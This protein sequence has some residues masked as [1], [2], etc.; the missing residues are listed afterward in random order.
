ML[1][2]ERPVLLLSL[3]AAP[4][5]WWLLRVRVEAVM[6]DR[7]A[8][9]R[10]AAERVR[11]LRPRARWQRYV[12]ALGVA[13]LGLAL[14]GLRVQEQ[15][16]LRRCHFVVD[17][18]ASMLTRDE[19]AG[20]ARFDAALRAALEDALPDHVERFVY[21]LDGQR[22]RPLTELAPSVSVSDLG[23]TLR[24]QAGD[25]AA[26][27][28]VAL[29]FAA[30]R[31]PSDFIVVC[32][33][34]AGLTTWPER[35]SEGDRVALRGF[36]RPETT[37]SG[38]RV[39]EVVDPWPLPEI[40]LR[41]E[42][43]GHGP[44]RALTVSL[45]GGAASR[46]VAVDEAGKVNVQR[47]QGGTLWLRQEPP[48]LL[49]V[50]DEARV[51]VRGPWSPLLFVATRPLATESV[52]EAATTLLRFFEGVLG[53]EAVEKAAFIAQAPQRKAMSIVDGGRLAA[54]PEDGI[55]RILFA[56]EVAAAS[57]WT[58]LSG[59]PDWDP[60]LDLLDGLDPTELRADQCCR[61]G[62]AL[63]PDAEVLLRFDGEPLA[64]LSRRHRLLWIGLELTPKL[65]A[66]PTLPLLLLR[67][68][69]RLVDAGEVSA[70]ETKGLDSAERE[71]AARRPPTA[72]PDVT[73]WEPPRPLWLPLVGLASCCFL[74]LAVRP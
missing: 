39:V 19:V 63:P 51:Q 13:A 64:F 23:F 31:G 60:S 67:S 35:G 20:Q 41:V 72:Q 25:A 65:V 44:A 4:L 30:E 71:V 9:W 48:D 22:L 56:S 36:G 3:L 18:S 52:R 53:A 37:N 68:L 70:V 49:A 6:S 61:L 33:D 17:A 10:R 11:R 32:S 50:D 26:D 54:W 16:G 55:V 12:M 29:R 21:L 28:S 59:L 38:L 74:L 43:Y 24:A 45:A 57:T 7:V 1:D 5:V 14:A 73:W 27:L 66:R 8:L 15:A 34:G 46:E 2:F 69:Q 58:P 47:G 62:V 40:E 42:T